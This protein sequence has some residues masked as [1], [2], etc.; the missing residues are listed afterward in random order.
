MNIHN[1][2]QLKYFFFLII[3]SFG[4]PYSSV[5]SQVINIGKG[6]YTRTLPSGEKSATDQ[7]GNPIL[8]NV[9]GNFT[10]LEWFSSFVLVTTNDFW[11]NV[12]FRYAPD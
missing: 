11:S 2:I 8:P 4:I 3:F 12:L 1:S 9:A 10:K 5:H 6:S 7:N